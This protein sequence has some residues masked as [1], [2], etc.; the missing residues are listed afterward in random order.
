MASKSKIIAELFEADGDI[1]ASAL[2]NVVVTPAAVSDQANTSTGGLSMPTGTTAQRPSSPDTGESRMNTTSGSLEFYDGSGWVSTN[3]IPLLN[4]VTGNIVNDAATQL[5]FSLSNNTDSV[6]VVFSEGGSE[7]HTVSAAAVSSGA[8][9]LT[10]PSQVYGQT[11]GDTISISVKNS[12]G[13]PSSNSITKT[14]LAL[15]TGGTITTSGNIRTHAF[16]TSSNLVVPTGYTLSAETLVLAGGGS[17]GFHSGGG[18]GA[19]GLLWYSGTT[20]DTKTPN[21]TTLSIPAG[22][23]T[24]TVGA[25]AG[26]AAS[27]GSYPNFTGFRTDSPADGGA[28]GGGSA[29]GKDGNNSSFAISGASTYTAIGGGGGGHS[30]GGG[31]DGGCGGGGARNR[32]GGSGT[33]G[34]GQ[35]GGNAQY[36]NSNPYPA[37]GGGGTKSVGGGATGTKSGDGGS[38]HNFTSIF[39]STYGASGGFGGG[40]GGNIQYDPNNAGAGGYGGGG[41][42]SGS[43]EGASGGNGTANSGGGG[44]GSRYNA[45][46]S[47]LAQGG[48]GIILIKYDKST[49]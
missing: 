18:G 13:T 11:A 10:I 34:Q 21:A 5:V 46:Q 17:G 12:D 24:C 41:S 36:G 9:T 8:L 14:V 43:S 45:S 7:F 23:H 39:G 35:N 20:V 25:G 48:S 4:S 47:N 31:Y 15:P 40:G 49:L 1:I 32:A 2:D 44:G 30:G 26:R 3:L 42:G 37:D 22:T 19:G 27:G 16:T 38:G 28:G 6:D 29:P 33:S